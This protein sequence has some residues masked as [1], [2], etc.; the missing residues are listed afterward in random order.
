MNE[1]QQVAM[2]IAAALELL[3]RA[4]NYLSKVHELQA[5][6]GATPEALQALLDEIK[7]NSAV[8]QAN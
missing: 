6:G 2:I 8:I 1:A 5:N 3:S 7:A 4:Q